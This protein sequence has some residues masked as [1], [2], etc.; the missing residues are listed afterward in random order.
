MQEYQ[1]TPIDA[2]MGKLPFQLTG[3]KFSGIHN[4]K[5]Y[6]DGTEHSI[7]TKENKLQ[8][9]VFAAD[10]STT[11]SHIKHFVDLVEKNP[12]KV[13]LNI[14]VID[15]SKPQFINELV[16]KNNAGI[17]VYTADHQAN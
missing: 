9:I 6:K 14:L 1:T 11:A 3:N 12:G 10:N 7:T 4:L 16:A 8:F 5:D 17:S 2:L 15:S 13:H